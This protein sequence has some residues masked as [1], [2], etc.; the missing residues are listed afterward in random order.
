MEYDQFDS[1]QPAN[2]TTVTDQVN[3][4]IEQIKMEEREPQEEVDKWNLTDE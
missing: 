4:I 1:P 3:Q 2:G